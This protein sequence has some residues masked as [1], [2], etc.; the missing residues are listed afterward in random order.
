[1]KKNIFR[2]KINKKKL[3]LSLP[4]TLFSHQS[5]FGVFCGYFSAKFLSPRLPSLVF[6]LGK[7]KF[8]LHHWLYSFLFLIFGL[9]YNFLPLFSFSFG[10]FGGMI[11]QGIYCYSDWHRV[12]IL[13]R[14][15]LNAINRTANF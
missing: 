7:I 13:K 1:M 9:K 3:L 4:L 11:F 14:K 5:L 10:F 2:G 8:H 12:I 15:N 6:D